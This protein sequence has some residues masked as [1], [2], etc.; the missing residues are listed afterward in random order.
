MLPSYVFVHARPS[1]NPSSSRHSALPTSDPD[2]EVDSNK[3]ALLSDRGDVSQR[4]SN[5]SGQ[6]AT[7]DDPP[8]RS[9]RQ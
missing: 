6:L 8:P 2:D 7:R 1:N 4:R 9:R 5:S 3:L